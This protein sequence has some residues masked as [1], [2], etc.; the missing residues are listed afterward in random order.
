MICKAEPDC[1]ISRNARN[2]I[3]KTVNYTSERRAAFFQPRKL[4]VGAVKNIIKREKYCAD[5][6]IFRS[7]LRK[8]NSADYRKNYRAQS[9]LIRSNSGSVNSLYQ[10]E[11]ERS[12]K[13]KVENFFDLNLF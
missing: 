5:E 3:G 6:E 1:K 11:C 2:V 4:S 13:N 8:N 9:N 7:A 12:K 10:K